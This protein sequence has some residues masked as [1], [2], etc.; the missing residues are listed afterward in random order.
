MSH[1]LGV[2]L[3]ST[4]YG[5]SLKDGGACLIEGGRITVAIAEERISRVKHAGGFTQAMQYCLEYAGLSANDL[6][7]VVA[8]SCCEKLR[9]VEEVAKLVGV[10][11]K[12][13]AVVSHHLSHAHSAFWASPFTEAIIIVMDAGGNV[14]G[15]QD[16]NQW[17]QWPR[18][19][20]SYYLARGS[21]I[22]LIDTDFNNPFEAGFGEVYRAFTHYLG[23]DSY[24][25]SGNTMALAALPCKTSYDRGHVFTFDGESIHSQIRAD[26]R[27]PIDM[28]RCF[29][30]KEGLHFPSPRTDGQDIT[31][32][33]IAVAQLVQSSLEEALV[34]KVKYLMQRTGVTNVCLAGGV[35]L[36]CVAN[37]RLLKDAGVENLFVQPAAADTGQCLGNASYGMHQLGLSRT[38]A[39]TPFDVYLGR[40]V[41]PPRQPERYENADIRIVKAANPLQYVAGQLAQGKVVAWASGRSEFGPRAL[42][43]RSLLGDPRNQTVRRRLLNIKGRESFM[44]FAPSVLFERQSEYFELSIDSPYMLITSKVHLAKRS[45]IPAVVHSDGTARV[46]SVR[47]DRVPEFH[48]LIEYFAD[49]TAIPMVLNTSLNR[50]G[51]PIADSFEDAWRIFTET[52]VDCFL[53]AGMLAEKIN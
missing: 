49:I 5:K 15:P 13:V 10:A 39:R 19:Q 14:I 30:D 27:N 38:D 47:K 51:E 18:E 3:G 25:Q 53:G 31:D 34:A 24:T 8:S 33:H 44:P 45:Q 52:D 42:G 2:N 48:K 35:A 9:S 17:W 22:Q 6:D 41:I 21:Q 23:W 50:K 20:Q 29:A 40:Q 36:N 7:L 4:G 1:V 43:G 12:K 11:A 32:A 16:S 26:P 37:S 46:H 28:V